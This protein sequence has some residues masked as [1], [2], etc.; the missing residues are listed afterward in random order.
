MLPHLPNIVVVIAVWSPS[1]LMV[2]QRRM[3]HFS[4]V[5]GLFTIYYPTI[6]HDVGYL[7]A[8][9]HKLIECSG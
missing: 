5:L 1:K 7:L 4:F 3:F 9:Y 8:G 2:N 6:D